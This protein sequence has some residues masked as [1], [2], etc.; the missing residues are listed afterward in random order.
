MRKGAF[1]ATIL[2]L[3]ITFALVIRIGLAPPR[4]PNI[5][6]TFRGYTNNSAGARVG[7]FAVSNHEPSTVEW[8]GPVIE[9]PTPT[10]VMG[11]SGQF[12]PTHSMLR[13]GAS[14]MLTVPPP[15]NHSLWAV[16]LRVYPD[17]GA[18]REIRWFVLDTLPKVGFKPGN[19]TRAYGIESDWIE[20]GK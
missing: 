10:N 19:Q 20:G 16:H 3:F 11:H 1:I 6:I 14:T 13:A 5:S 15:S 12:V 17:V 18:A 7:I 8:F 4:R 9:F 2:I